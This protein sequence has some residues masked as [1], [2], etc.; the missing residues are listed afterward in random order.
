MQTCNKQKEHELA[1]I[2][3]QYEFNTRHPDV[4]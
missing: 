3:E 1:A 4:Y 2:M